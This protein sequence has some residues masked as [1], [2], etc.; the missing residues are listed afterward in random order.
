MCSFAFTI[1]ICKLTGCA[2]QKV[3]YLCNDFLCCCVQAQALTDA[4]HVPDKVI[5]L[6][7]PHALLLDRVK[8]RRI[9]YSTGW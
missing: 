2:V 4:G 3:W 6:D 5:M 1:R 8:Y 7:G 9:D